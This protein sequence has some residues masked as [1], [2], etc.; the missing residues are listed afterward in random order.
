[1][2]TE[3]LITQ[4]LA[5]AF[6]YIREE[7]SIDFYA[8]KMNIDALELNALLYDVNKK[9]FPEWMEWIDTLI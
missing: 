4:F 2:K 3:E 5:L 1:M 7:R 8:G 6:M 9:G